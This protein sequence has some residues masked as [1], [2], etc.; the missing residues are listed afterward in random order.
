MKNLLVVLLVL[1]MATGCA[2]EQHATPEEI[3]RV[4]TLQAEKELLETQLETIEGEAKSLMEQLAEAIAKGEVEAQT[5]VY[6]ELEQKKATWDAVVADWKSKNAAQDA[7][8]D[9][10][11]ERAGA[12]LEGLLPFLPEP[13]KPYTVPITYLAGLLA[14]KRSRENLGKSLQNITK[15]RVWEALADIGRAMGYAHTNAEPEKVMKAASTILRKEGDLKNAEIVE[16]TAKAVESD[17]VR[18]KIA[19]KVAEVVKEG[20]TK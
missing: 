6:A 13:L 7:V 18:N 20:E 16:R 12:P 14:F 8:I 2:F 17:R 4:E 5:R 10:V 11:R 1:F 19:E 15:G 3:Q 9:E